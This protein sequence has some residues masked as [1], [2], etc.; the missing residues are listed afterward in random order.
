[1]VNYAYTEDEVCDRTPLG[2]KVAPLRP[3]NQFILEVEKIKEDK[4]IPG[5]TYTGTRFIFISILKMLCIIIN[6]LN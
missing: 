1:M 4:Y 3:D 5:N 2:I 6:C